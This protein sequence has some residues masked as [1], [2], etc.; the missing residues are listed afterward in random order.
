MSHFSFKCFYS[1]F[2]D[3]YGRL[4]YS[5][6]SWKHQPFLGTQAFSCSLSSS[7][8]PAW[9][10]LARLNEEKLNGVQRVSKMTESLVAPLLV[11]GNSQMGP[12]AL[13]VTNFNW[14][15]GNESA[16]TTECSESSTTSLLSLSLIDDAH[17]GVT[18]PY[19]HTS[20]QQSPLVR[21]RI[22]HLDGRQIR[23]AIVTSDHKQ[24][25]VHGS[26]ARVSSAHAH[27]G[28]GRPLV[29]F[30]VVTLDALS[31]VR[32]IMAANGEQETVS[33]LERSKQR[34][35]L[36]RGWGGGL[37]IYTGGWDF[38]KGL[39]IPVL[40]WWGKV[41]GVWCSTGMFV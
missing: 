17:S 11:C 41:C 21:P 20:R 40:Q 29:Q 15:D 16:I 5:A 7:R 2:G 33:N 19:A 3:S 13:S 12:S 18:P 35:S 14:L 30:W 26:D 34:V 39:G 25:T 8:T 32:T 24:K 31:N 6:T 38:L 28:D 1:T 4:R 27:V 23:R 9:A 22:V 36:A 10:T 37:C